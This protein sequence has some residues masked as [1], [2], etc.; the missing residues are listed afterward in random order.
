MTRTE[1]S[2]LLTFGRLACEQEGL[3][4]FSFTTLLTEGHAGQFCLE[5]FLIFRIAGM[6]QAVGQLE[7]A[8]SFQLPGFDTGLDELNNDAVGARVIGLRQGFHLA[9]DARGEAY[10]LT[11]QLFGDRHGVRIHQ[12]RKELPD[13]AGAGSSVAQAPALP[14]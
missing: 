3:R 2:E 14:P 1:P 10:A 5:T 12:K 6:R 4:V 8:F 11:D 9:G 7:D 13:A